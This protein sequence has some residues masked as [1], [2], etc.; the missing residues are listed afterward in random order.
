MP[1]GHTPGVEYV[2]NEPFREAFL[3]SDI[4][5]IEVAR[6]MGWMRKNK[7]GTVVGDS[8]KA[9]RKL[10]VKALSPSASKVDVRTYYCKTVT[11]EEA[12]KLL[13]LFPSLD[14]VDVGV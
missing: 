3:H 9:L 11:Y 12:V 5:G 6:H 4:T 7:R 2:S 8:T 13:R 1:K 14:P 10:G